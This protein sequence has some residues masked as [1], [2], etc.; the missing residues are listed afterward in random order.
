MNKWNII[1]DKLKK[2]KFLIFAM[3]WYKE[4]IK[5]IDPT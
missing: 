2:L 5:I 3:L 4:E 1:P